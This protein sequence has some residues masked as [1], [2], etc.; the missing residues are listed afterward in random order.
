MIQRKD[1]EKEKGKGKG[2]GKG[3]RRGK[4]QGQPPSVG[5]VEVRG[6]PPRV[7]A[8]SPGIGVHPP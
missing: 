4:G 3:K 2:K 1:M 6:L 8:Y 7:E 5:V